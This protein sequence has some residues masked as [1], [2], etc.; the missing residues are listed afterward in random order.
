MRRNLEVVVPQV[1]DTPIVRSRLTRV[2]ASL[3]PRSSIYPLVSH[4]L[5]RQREKL[6]SLPDSTV[7][8][9]NIRGTNGSLYHGIEASLPCPNCHIVPLHNLCTTCPGDIA[10]HV[11]HS[12]PLPRNTRGEKSSGK[13]ECVLPTP[14]DPSCESCPTCSGQSVLPSEDPNYHLCGCE[15]EGREDSYH[16]IWDEPVPTIAKVGVS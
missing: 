4:H 14:F 13:T 12:M 9:E 2:S 7:F 10:V 11:Q 16:V 15:I 3:C 5:T 8:G 1:S 6:M